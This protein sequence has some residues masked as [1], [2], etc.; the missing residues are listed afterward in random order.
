MTA[1]FD[2]RECADN[3]RDIPEDQV[4]AD[5]L[6]TRI[7]AAFVPVSAAKALMDEKHKEAAEAKLWFEKAQEWRGELTAASARAEAAEA[8]VKVLEEALA[9]E[10]EENLWNAYN[11]G[12]VKDGRWSH[13]FMSDGEWLAKQCGFDPRINDY[14]DAAIR[15]AI[16]IAAR[17]ALGGEY[18][19]G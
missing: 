19:H 11:T 6:R 12:H 15:K 14:D 2:W 10:R 18:E 4:A 16:P 9:T 8:R 5:Y 7:E 17:Q 3:M 13:M 1:P